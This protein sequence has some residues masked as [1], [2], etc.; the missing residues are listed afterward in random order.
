MYNYNYL[1]DVL[2]PKYPDKI[3]LIVV[4]G[5]FVCAVI[6][7]LIGSVNFSIII[8]RIFYKDDIRTHGSGNA[9][10]TNMLRTHGTVPGLLTFGGDLL[11]TA[12]AVFAGALIYN[13]IGAYFA[14][15]FCIIGHIFPLYFH[16][17]GGKGVAT[18]A[19]VIAL[20]NIRT[21]IVCLIVFLV[22][23]I[24][25][26]YV[27]LGSIVAVM[28]YPIVLYNILNLFGANG[29]EYI[30][31]IFAFLIAVIV[32]IKHRTNIKKIFN[33]TESKISF[34]KHGTDKEEPKK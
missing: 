10:S 1:Q 32:V 15:F 30:G 18:V 27:S 19:M 14:G 24:F 12:V 33:H 28:V 8:S 7:Y 22:I 34:T 9:G 4:L 29:Y 20:T 25:T 2:F 23:V 16:F 26:K 13:L 5:C 31:V 17:K 11:K 3:M 21:F 6:G